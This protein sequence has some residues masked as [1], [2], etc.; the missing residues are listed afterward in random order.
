MSLRTGE[1]LLTPLPFAPKARTLYT[2]PDPLLAGGIDGA[3][4]GALEGALVGG[5]FLVLLVVLAKFVDDVV[6]FLLVVVVASMCWT[7]HKT[8]QMHTKSLKQ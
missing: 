1:S 4:V 3:L 2:F 5:A 6:F 7:T 8:T